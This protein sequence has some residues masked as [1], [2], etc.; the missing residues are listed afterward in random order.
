VEEGFPFGE[1]AGSAEDGVEHGDGV[2]AGAKD[3]DEDAFGGWDEE[4]QDRDVEG[5]ARVTSRRR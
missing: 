2:D 4:V 3:V 5:R 1:V